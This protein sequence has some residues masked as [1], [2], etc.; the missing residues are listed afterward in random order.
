MSLKLA[1]VEKR[2]SLNK[3]FQI[4]REVT[5]HSETIICEITDGL[6]TGR[7][8]AAGVSYDNETIESITKQI[9]ICW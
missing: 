2:W 5:T 4:S 8:E 3:P 9:E 7:G 6:W 1:V